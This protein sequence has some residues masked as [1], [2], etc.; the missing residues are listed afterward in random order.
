MYS[1]I[2][3]MFSAFAFD[4]S[5]HYPKNPKNSQLPS[6][7]V[8]R[9][10]APNSPTPSMV[11]QAVPSFLRTRLDFTC[12]LNNNLAVSFRI[13][14]VF[15]CINI[16]SLIFAHSQFT[17]KGSSCCIKWSKKVKRVKIGGSLGTRVLG[18]K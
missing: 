8:F 2:R 5:L 17:L 1:F 11:A 3:S 9:T 13:K 12:G 7:P 14:S 4:L 18:C 15:R 16:T 10:S 6:I